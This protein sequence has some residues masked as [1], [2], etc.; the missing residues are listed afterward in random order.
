LLWQV[1]LCLPWQTNMRYQDA[2]LQKPRACRLQHR[3]PGGFLW[4]RQARVGSELMVRSVQPEAILPVWALLKP[5]GH[6]E[7]P[8]QQDLLGWFD[9]AIVYS[10]LL[11]PLSV[12]RSES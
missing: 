9:A 4:Y 3:H 2:E 8:V 7:R 6:R 1:K 5:Q 11:P 12:D 10:L